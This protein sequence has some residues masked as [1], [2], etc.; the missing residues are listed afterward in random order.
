[1]SHSHHTLPPMSEQWQTVINEGWEQDVLPQVPV[2]YD[3]QA[4]QLHAIERYREF[5][6]SSDLLRG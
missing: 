3:Q 2:D 1:M 5:A 6:R 4:E